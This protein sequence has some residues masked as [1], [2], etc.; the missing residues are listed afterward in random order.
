MLLS[1]IENLSFSDSYEIMQF[2]EEELA[3]KVSRLPKI[4]S[5]APVG[6][7][8]RFE[9]VSLQLAD[10]FRPQ[11]ENESYALFEQHNP[12][13][14]IMQSFLRLPGINFL[15][16]MAGSLDEGIYSNQNHDSR[17][18]GRV[19][20][21]HI[22]PTALIEQWAAE[23]AGAIAWLAS[24]GL[25]HG[26][27]RP[28]NIFLDECDCVVARV[29]KSHGSFGLYEAWSE[30]FAFAS[31]FHFAK[32]GMELSDDKGPEALDLLKNLVFPE[33]GDSPLDKLITKCWM[34]GFAALVDLAIATEQLEGAKGGK[35]ATKFDDEYMNKKKVQCF[36]LLEGNL[37]A[38]SSMLGSE[39]KSQAIIA[40]TIC[41]S[42][43]K[44]V[45]I[46]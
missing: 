39:Q 31:I 1:V 18:E 6:I 43:A 30:Q 15:P 5:L 3:D 19:T 26:D 7:L 46:R 22:V 25:V 37:L 29:E 35:G 36:D 44:R 17:K 23:L 42:D 11:T 40:A 2:A 27:L 32:S 16:L 38:F 34:G 4:F 9:G 20:V 12:P 13:P 21:A 41:S 28:A 24:L 14:S 33:L 45:V 10:P 8:S